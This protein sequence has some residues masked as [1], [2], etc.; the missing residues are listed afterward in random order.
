[1]TLL[2][3]QINALDRSD[4]SFSTLLETVL[5]LLNCTPKSLNKGLFQHGPTPLDEWAL[6]WLL[7]RMRSNQKTYDDPQVDSRAWSL[8]LVLVTK[9]NTNTVAR[10]LDELKFPIIVYDS[11]QRLHELAK[12]FKCSQSG[13]SVQK[14]KSVTDPV[15]PSLI[16]DF[17]KQGEPSKSPQ[18]VRLAL[19]GVA[20]LI[21]ALQARTKGSPDDSEAFATQHLGLTIRMSSIQAAQTVG[22]F[23]SISTIIEAEQASLTRGSILEQTSCLRAVSFIWASRR[24]STAR[25]NKLA[26]A[27]LFCSQ[28]LVPALYHLSMLTPSTVEAKNL[29]RSLVCSNFLLPSLEE[30]CLE[31]NASH[32][33]VGLYRD[34][35]G[36]FKKAFDPLREAY[37][38]PIDSISMEQDDSISGLD[39]SRTSTDGGHTSFLSNIPFTPAPKNRLIPVLFALA[40]ETCGRGTLR[41]GSPQALWLSQFFT[42]LIRCLGID[43]SSPSPCYEDQAMENLTEL[44][45]LC[46]RHNFNPGFGAIETIAVNCTQLCGSEHFPSNDWKRFGACIQVDRSILTR[47]PQSEQSEDASQALDV[48]LNA[49]GSHDTTVGSHDLEVVEKT[50]V[51]VVDAF[52]QAREAPRFVKIWKG[53]LAQA[54]Q[55]TSQATSMEK[56]RIMS[57]IWW[58]ENVA[59]GIAPKLLLSLTQSQILEI[60][61]DLTRLCEQPQSNTF[62]HLLGPPIVVAHSLLST[63]WDESLAALIYEPIESF[64]INSSP[65]LGKSM[66][67]TIRSK[68]WQSLAITCTVW[69]ELH[70]DNACIRVTKDLLHRATELLIRDV[71]SLLSSE[72]YLDYEEL[73]SCWIYVVALASHELPQVARNRIE[74]IAGVQNVLCCLL[75]ILHYYCSGPIQQTSAI[76]HCP[77]WDGILAE[78]A[79]KEQFLLAILAVPILRARSLV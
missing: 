17:D 21:E 65:L 69:P 22:A 28:A 30:F 11:I 64:Y 54:F 26:D 6:R 49:M 8:S 4:D 42:D 35:F 62:I 14:D 29:L 20:R 72:A 67:R 37:K 18:E 57:H 45:L 15:V 38:G 9:L 52:V 79:S 55:T 58:G 27:R 71:K 60:F 16:P 63:S 24:G 53:Q 68:A 3:G 13:V 5:R 59:R 2:V 40:A 31:P 77:T 34:V 25:Q 12:K 48:F 44:L 32:D 7:K 33:V 61:E 50:L 47:L 41:T 23:L 73:L 1:M 78:I 51:Q 76:L 75:D 70:V 10:I 74:S 46:Q 19:E 36:P 56:G 39:S 66:P 43:L